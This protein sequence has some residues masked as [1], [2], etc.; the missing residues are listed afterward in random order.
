MKIF[1]TRNRTASSFQVIQNE[2]GTLLLTR[3][4]ITS[5]RNAALIIHNLGKESENGNGIEEV[6]SR[7]IEFEGTLKE[8]I[9]QSQIPLKSKKSKMPILIKKIAIPDLTT[10]HKR[11]RIKKFEKI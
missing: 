3:D 2:D 5:I 9:K 8:F 4:G 10:K 11:P 1:K 6:L 7:C